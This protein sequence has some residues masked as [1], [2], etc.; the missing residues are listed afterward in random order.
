MTDYFIANRYIATAERDARDILKWLRQTI[1]RFESKYSLPCWNASF[2]VVRVL[3]S[4]TTMKGT[5]N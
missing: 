5:L 3:S 1:P 2:N 4:E